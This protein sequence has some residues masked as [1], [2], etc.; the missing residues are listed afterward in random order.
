[1]ELRFEST[2]LESLYCNSNF[3]SKHWHTTLVR[4]TRRRLQQIKAA[5]D[6]R[7]LRNVAGARLE[8][9]KGDRAGTSSVRVDK[10]YRLILRFITDEQSGRNAVI[11]DL[12]DYH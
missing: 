8:Q 5:P 7:T 1:M 6:E 2:E 11:I 9:L 4:A 12:V 3:R 10:Q